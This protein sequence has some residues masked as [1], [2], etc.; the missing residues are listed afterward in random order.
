[1]KRRKIDYIRILAIL[2]IFCAISYFYA[3]IFAPR[4]IPKLLRI[5]SLRRPMTI[6]ILGTD[7]T[8]DAVT[9]EPIPEIN[10]RTDTILLMHIDP[11]RYKMY[12]LSIPRDSLVE[13][14][15]F[16]W[17]KINAAHV[18][19]GVG[20]TEKTIEKLTGIKVDYF[21]KVNPYASIKLVDLL[22][23]INVYIDKDMYYV[24]RAQNLTIN[25][26]QGWHKLAGKEAEGYIR[27]RHDFLGDI[28]RIGRQQN[29][30]QTVFRSFTR[31][32]NLLK[33]PYAFNIAR[34]YI[35]TDLPLLKI[36]RLANFARML[37]P[38]DVLTFTASGENSSH[39]TVGAIWQL[40]HQ[41]LR[42][43]AQDYF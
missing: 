16:G 14:P 30:L 18:F 3:N 38:S 28:G 17:Q 5:G 41:D 11:M 15:G 20:L 8:F 6:L 34:R 12:L 2:T 10:G 7:I 25:L 9:G 29:L 1:M 27:F 19:G 35:Q 26:K 33:A 4:L 13:I 21:I 42:K 37:S 36:I 43:I 31:P 40:D 24:D 39:P 23:G 22:G 32:S